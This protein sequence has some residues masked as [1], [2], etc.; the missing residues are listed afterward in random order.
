[1]GA[2]RDI[3]GAGPRL[4]G[5]DAS[6]HQQGANALLRGLQSC[7]CKLNGIV[8]RAARAVDLITNP[9]NDVS[10]CREHVSVPF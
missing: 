8:F 5:S 3:E 7:S 6:I 9:G 2:R 4:F 10:E 1:M